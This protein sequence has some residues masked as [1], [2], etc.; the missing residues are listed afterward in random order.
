VTGE[1][2]GIRSFGEDLSAADREHPPVWTLLA[3]AGV[4]S[5]VFASLHSHPLP[6]DLGAHP[7]FVP[8]AFAPAADCHPAS[9]RPFQ[10]LNLAASRAS[11]LNVIRGVPKRQALRFLA[12]A[13]FVG[14]R[15][16]TLAAAAAQLAVERLR[17]ERVVR[18]RTFQSVL[19][20]DLFAKLLQDRTPRF[21]TF[22]T[23]HVASSMHR[24]WAAAHPE[25]Y[26]HV[27]HS[28]AW[29]AT[30]RDEIPFAMR[31]AEDMIERLMAFVAS[32]PGWTLVVAASM[33]QA[34]T[35]AGPVAPL[36]IVRGAERFLESLGAPPGTWSK[37]P[38]M[39]PQINVVVDAEREAEVARRLATLRIAGQDVDVDRKPGGFFSISLGH[40]LHEGVARTAELLGR[41]VPLSDIG[42]DAVSLQD[43]AGSCAYHVPEGVLVVHEPGAARRD[44]ARG[45]VSTREVAP[46]ILSRLGVTPP[47]YM[48]SPGDL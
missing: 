3:R 5:G 12:S 19:A 20:F 24:Y 16:R 23:N 34:A 41:T 39:E 7:F 44:T 46:W 17:P 25:D 38:A 40:P 28:A 31:R 43:E 37:R 30:W 47:A 45:R 36:V 11:G 1:L 4:P 9:V 18:R 35:T 6:A 42:L 8:D 10:E 26:A 15:P 21:A 13:P 2:H 29:R 48:V 22:F 33:G 27:E 32:R 14:V